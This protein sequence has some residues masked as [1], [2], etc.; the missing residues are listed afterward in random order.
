[1]SKLKDKNS[2]IIKRYKLP[3]VERLDSAE[4]FLVVP[5]VDEHLSVILYTVR[6]HP[7]KKIYRNLGYLLNNLEYFV[8]SY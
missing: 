7:G 6:Q 4:E 8:I 2:S 3:P 1:M 5:A